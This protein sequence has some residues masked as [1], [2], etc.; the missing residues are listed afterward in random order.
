MRGFSHIVATLHDL[1]TQ[2]A[3]FKRTEKAEVLFPPRK[4]AM[5]KPPILACLEKDK[6][7]L[8]NTDASTC[9]SGAVL[10][11]VGVTRKW[12]QCSM[13]VGACQKPEVLYR[14]FKHEA[15]TLILAMKKI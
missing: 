15:A 1:T 11:Q 10:M 2:A 7:F 4:E 3:E 6:R 8:V 9:V 14:T 12:V 5:N 13:Q